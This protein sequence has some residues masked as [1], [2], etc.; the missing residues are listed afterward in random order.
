MEIYTP[1]E[2]YQIKSGRHINQYLE[3]LMFQ[4][5][6]FVAYLLHYMKTKSHPD[7]IKNSCQMHLE[8][9]L[10]Q[11]ENRPVTMPCPVCHQEPITHFS[12]VSSRDSGYSMS[13]EYSACDDT[14]CRG[15]VTIGVDNRTHLIEW[16]PVKFSKILLSSKEGYQENFIKMIKTACG[17][18]KGNMTHQRAFA[19][20]TQPAQTTQP[21]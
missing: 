14:H 20:F 21:A 16:I 5:Y 8:W 15:R 7:S 18:D 11:G 4:D 10:V 17:I 9:L 3:V 6:S 12:V 2:P 13:T 1:T 19:F